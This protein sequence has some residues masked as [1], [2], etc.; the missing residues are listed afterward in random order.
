MEIRKIYGFTE[1]TFSEGGKALAVPLRK[2]TAVAVF[3]NPFAGR[4]VQELKPLTDASGA[5]AVQL[6]NLARQLLHP[7][8]VE[9]VGKGGVVGLAGE[10]EHV[11]AMLT[12]V[13]GDAMRDVAGGGKAWIS[14][15]TKRG[16]PGVTLDIPT[17]HRLALYVRSHYDGMTVTLHDAPHPDEIALV[18][19]YVS[20]GRPHARVGG[21]TKEQVKGEDGIR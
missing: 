7:H 21:L 15:M 4:F 12:N 9:G 10:Q 5:L 8:S 3:K 14:S 20:G 11:V 2:A 16:G 6:G 19:C 18:L 1:E 13:F 17:N